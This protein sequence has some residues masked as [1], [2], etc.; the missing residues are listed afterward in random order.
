MRG[1]AKDIFGEQLR[2]VPPFVPVG[3]MPKS[4]VD[5][6]RAL[7]P[8]GDPYLTEIAEKVYTV[9]RDHENI[10]CSISGGWDSDTM[11]DMIIRFGGKEKTKFVFFNT[12]LEYEATLRHLDDLEKTYGI[13][14]DKRKP[15]M[16]VP[17]SVKKYG[18]PFWSKYVSDMISRL[19]K[20][21]FQWEDEPY[22][23]LLK[24][25]PHCKAALKWWC[26]EWKCEKPELDSSFN[27][28]RNPGMKEFLMENPPD[29]LISCEC[30]NKAKKQVA[31]QAIRESGYDLSCVGVRKCE[32]GKRSTAITSCFDRG[33]EI[34]VFRPLFWMTD[35]QKELYRETFGI[36]RSDCY[37]VWGMKRTGC[38]G[39]PFGKEFEEELKLAKMYEPKRY[40][41]MIAVF[42]WS[43]EYT[44]KYLEFRAKMKG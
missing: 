38:V 36:V 9:V 11:A 17:A 22:D 41:M 12:G 32:G 40:A 2:I 19:Q 33:A 10:M 18:V 8:A 34:D 15:V 28:R 14:I 4:V 5:V 37:E 6:S 21:G 42:G 43:Y 39:C 29:V 23:V 3:D 44:R 13:K 7:K 25:Y 26:N 27:I 35:A 31:H 24:R 30:C 20:H 16:T 1:P